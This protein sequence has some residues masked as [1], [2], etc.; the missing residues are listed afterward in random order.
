MLWVDALSI[1]QADDDERSQQVCLMRAIYTQASSVEIWLGESFDNIELASRFFEE[2][3]SGANGPET[4]CSSS[5]SIS[6]HRDDFD[7]DALEGDA[8]QAV[9]TLE[10]IKKFMQGAW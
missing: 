10:A 6:L 8:K 7:E 9:Q 5:I 4:V 1:N 2:F 3:A